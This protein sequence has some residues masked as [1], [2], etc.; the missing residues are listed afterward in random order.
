MRPVEIVS[1]IRETDVVSAPASDMSSLYLGGDRPTVTV[2]SGGHGGGDGGRRA[3]LVVP[4]IDGGGTIT[5]R[6]SGSE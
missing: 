3:V 6:T 2:T 5:S 4:S 1:G